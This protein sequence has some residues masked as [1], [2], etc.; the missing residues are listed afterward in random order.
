MIYLVSLGQVVL[1]VVAFIQDHSQP[2]GSEQRTVG[3]VADLE[4]GHQ[5]SIRCQHHV[6]LLQLTPSQGLH[7]AVVN[8]N[9]NVH[10]VVD[11]L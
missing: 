9:L 2:L 6:V 4:F 8:A 11:V 5:G 7:C 3:I 10:P 1:D